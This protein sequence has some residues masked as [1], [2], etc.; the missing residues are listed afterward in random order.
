[1]YTLRCSFI[2]MP[3][4]LCTPKSKWLLA[5]HHRFLAEIAG[6]GSL[7]QDQLLKHLPDI[8]YKKD[9]QD[10]NAYLNNLRRENNR[11]EYNFHRCGKI[12][13]DS[14]MLSNLQYVAFILWQYA[15]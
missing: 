8:E 12:N 4:F 14:G 10:A 7:A 9:A 6:L 11:A 5:G 3:M 2:N 1:M 13:Y 15:Y